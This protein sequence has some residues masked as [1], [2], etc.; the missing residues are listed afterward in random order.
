MGEITTGTSL[1]WYKMLVGCISSH[2]EIIQNHCLPQNGPVGL[3]N[4]WFNYSHEAFKRA[5]SH[6]G[7][8]IRLLAFLPLLIA[9]IRPINTAYISENNLG[10]ILSL[11]YS[12]FELK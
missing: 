10:I 2:L 6:F 1:L 5:V 11:A 3:R 8:N 12:I 4:F 9:F 7:F